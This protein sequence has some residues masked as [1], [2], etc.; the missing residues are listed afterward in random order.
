[1]KAKPIDVAVTTY[2]S[3]RYLDEALAG[4]FKAVRVK[5]LIV[6]DHHSTD[7][8]VEIAKKY[9]AEVFYEN[10]SLGYARQLAISKVSTPI[11]MFLDSDLVFLPPFNWYDGIMRLLETNEDWGAVVMRVTEIHYEK[12]RA[13]YNDFWHRNVPATIR[14]GFTTGST[15]IKRE[16]LEDLQI[17]AILDARE[18]RYMELHILNRKKLKIKYFKC[19][20]IHYF[21]HAKDKGSWA[22]ANERTLTGIKKFPYVFFRRIAFAPLKAIPPMLYY[23]NPKILTWNTRHWLNY[24]RG[25]LQPLKYRKLKRGVG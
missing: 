23:R 25:F 5:R 11:F 18:D 2:N 10:V 14:F 7:K 12:P 6:V 3:E 1:M 20:G 17:P 24:L 13:Q 8:T 16:A 15:F 22:G 21:D 19:R 4:L 9:G